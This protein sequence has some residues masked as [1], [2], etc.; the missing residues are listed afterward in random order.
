MRTKQ[1]KHLLSRIAIL[2]SHVTELLE[3][4]RYDGRENAHDVV[5]TGETLEQYAERTS[6]ASECRCAAQ[7]PCDHRY[8]T[9][10]EPQCPLFSVRPPIMLELD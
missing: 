1:R 4:L 5:R 9:L 10:H 2:D 8:R 7:S 3:L 6:S